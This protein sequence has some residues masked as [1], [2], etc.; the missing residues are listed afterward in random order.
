MKSQKANHKNAERTATNTEHRDE[1]PKCHSNTLQRVGP[2]APAGASARW[3]CNAC[4][5][6]FVAGQKL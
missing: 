6:E 4:R 5:Y 1:C 2:P 3:R